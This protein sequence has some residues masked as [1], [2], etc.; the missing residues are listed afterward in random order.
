MLDRAAGRRSARARRRRPPA[1]R[2]GVV[3][4]RRSRRR[5]RA[6]HDDARSR[7]APASRR[8]P[9][10]RR[11]AAV[12]ARAHADVARRADPAAGHALLRA[13]VDPRRRDDRR[14]AAAARP[15]R[16]RGGRSCA[17]TR[18]TSSRRARC[19]CCVEPR[20]ADPG[21]RERQPRR[22]HLPRRRALPLHA[23]P[24]AARG[25]VAARR[26]PRRATSRSCASRSATAA[27]LAPDRRAFYGLLPRSISHEGYSAKPA[28]SYWDD[29]WG[30]AGYNDAAWLAGALGDAAAAAR[31]AAPARRVPARPARVD[32]RERGGAPHRR[33]SRAPRTSATSTRPRRR[34][35]CR[36]AASRPRCRRRC[37][38]RTFERYWRELVGAAR[39]PR[40]W[41]GLHALR[42]A[43]S[44]AAFVRLGWRDARHD[45]LATSSSPTGARAAWNQWAE[46]VGRD[47]ARA[48][49][50]RR[51]AARLGRAPTTSAPRS[52]CSRTSATPTARSCSRPGSPPR[53][54]PATGFAIERLPTPYGPLSYAVTATDRELVLRIGPGDG[55][56]RRPRLPVA[57]RDPAGPGPA[58]RPARALARRFAPSS[59]SPTV[60]PPST[61][62]EPELHDRVDPV[63]RRLPLGLRH[64]RLP[65]R[66][67]AARRRRRAEHLAALPHT[68]GLV[69]RRRHRRRRLRSLPPLR[70][71]TSRSCAS[72]ACRR[73]ASASSWSRVLPDGTGAVNE[74][75]P[76]LLRP[77]R[78][79]A[80]RGRHRADRD[81]L[82]LGPAGRARRPRRLAQPRHRG[83]VRRLRAGRVP[84]RSTT[85]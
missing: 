15:P 73:T 44:S 63:S 32:R 51:H 30:L 43:H 49:L 80:A 61:S 83:L 1:A 48:A 40:A 42:A 25:G 22:V 59:R 6:W 82:P 13:L 56:A 34:S 71:A 11:D 45:A 17:G 35:R 23:R 74:A 5:A 52:T 64:L 57:V 68:P 21:A 29:F 12:V 2:G 55:P 8:G 81:A 84:P 38:A 70:R 76:R 85:A 46:V 79:R 72:S 26:R 50:R 9:A 65:D 53:G 7:R 62:P 39:R 66:G 36:P 3:R 54:S 47:S 4:R 67:L 10:D 37:C 77:A 24:R 19:P 14:G 20:G 31:L 58:R 16:R 60:P 41:D 33:T 27:N 28:Y 18:R 69:A 78:R 75:G